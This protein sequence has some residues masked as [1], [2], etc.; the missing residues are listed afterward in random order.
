[1]AD[2]YDAEPD[3]DEHSAASPTPPSSSS[4]RKRTHRGR[5]GSRGV[6][7]DLADQHSHLSN[8]LE[9]RESLR[10]AAHTAIERTRRE[11]IRQKV[12]ELR[13]LV[14]SCASQEN[15]QKVTILEKTVDYIHE[16]HARLA[17]LEKSS[18]APLDS[19]SG[20]SS[21]PAM[22]AA[23]GDTPSRSLYNSHYQFAD[24]SVSHQRPAYLNRSNPDS[25]PVRSTPYSLVCLAG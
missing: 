24:P 15:I 22:P 20:H 16:L 19:S 5:L 2:D 8:R 9:E 18:L 6:Q 1:M 12:L 11:K 14:P 25:W 23:G 3:F 7:R 13:H 4:H 21:N 17:T 10:K